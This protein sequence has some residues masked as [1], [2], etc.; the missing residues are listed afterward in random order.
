ML[1][2]PFQFTCSGINYWS[3]HLILFV[4]G[5]L[6]ASDERDRSRLLRCVPALPSDEDAVFA[7]WDSGSMR[8]IWINVLQ[9]AAGSFGLGKL[10]LARG[11]AMAALGGYR[12]Y[13]SKKS[14]S[15]TL[16]LTLLPALSKFTRQHYP[17]LQSISLYGHS[18]GA[19]LLIEALLADTPADSLPIRE[20]VFMGGARALGSGDLQQILPHINWRSCIFYSRSDRVLMVRPSTGKYIGRHPLPLPDGA[21][22]DKVFNQD[23]GIGHTDYWHL[24]YSI[25]QQVRCPQH[26]RL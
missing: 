24:L 16:A 11:M 12:H 8:D 19:R 25:L 22:T 17:D 13:S 21:Q 18:L 9:G 1:Q 3:I 4:H 10:G 20:L 15:R 6:S 14:H 23:L 5:Y 2:K 26:E 7:F